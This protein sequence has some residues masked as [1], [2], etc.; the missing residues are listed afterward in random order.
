MTVWYGYR[1]AP[2]EEI[3]DQVQCPTPLFQDLQR[4]WMV[5]TLLIDSYRLRN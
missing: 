3:L 1:S 2:Y 4:L 5:R